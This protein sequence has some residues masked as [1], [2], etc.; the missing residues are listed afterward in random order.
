MGQSKVRVAALFF[1]MGGALVLLAGCSKREQV[2]ATRPT[3][4][5]G[6]MTVASLVPAATDLIVGMGAAEH[7][8]AVSN[9]DAVQLAGRE[10]PRAGGYGEPD[11]E[12]LSTL[13][14]RVMI[15]QMEPTRLPTGFLEKVERRGI[16]L[17]NVKINTLA[18]VLETLPKLGRAIGEPQKADALLGMINQR[19][20]AVRTKAAALPRVK[21][22]LT[23][24]ELGE[25]LVGPGSFLAD[26]LHVA[27]G[28]NA[29]DS[30]N[31]A[32]PSADTETLVTLNPDVVILLKPEAKVQTLD[33]AK[34]AWSRLPQ[35]GAVAKGKIYLLRDAYVLQP[36]SHIADV[37]E[38]LFA[39][40]H[41]AA[42]GGG[43]GQVKP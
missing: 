9:Y 12:L 37:A 29:A 33:R 31:A 10:L 25:T 42:G 7:L 38:Q 24:D 15:I 26:L 8:V 35:V 4:L 20:E 36:G 30:L 41:P 39:C 6:P 13:K 2:A 5:E 34:K 11:W 32:W 17:V 14:P 27:G 19:L 16:Q 43:V 21:T 3:E 1:F 28:E 18:D 22:L 23:L 40:L